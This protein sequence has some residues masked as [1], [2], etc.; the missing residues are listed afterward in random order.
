MK[1]SNSFRRSEL[2]D[3]TEHNADHLN[4]DLNTDLNTGQYFEKLRGED[5]SA[6]FPEVANWLY[7]ANIKLENKSSERKNF[8]M[9]NFFLAN[10]L[11]LVYSV[12]LLALVVA[13]CNMPVTQTETAGQMITLVVPKDNA[14][15]QAKM[16][17]LP[18]IKNAQ[19]TSNENTNNVA[20]Q[21]LYRIV[22]PDATKEQTSRRCRRGDAAQ[23]DLV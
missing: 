21:V 5:H 13:A 19:V 2:K 17:T 8:S 20:E 23:V 10:K 11:R 15:F 12:I 3:K 22:L 6:S 14:D 18:W 9:R 1:L 7:K 4:T 16:N